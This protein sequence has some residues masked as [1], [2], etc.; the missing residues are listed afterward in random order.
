MVESN[1]VVVPAG[2]GGPPAGQLRQLLRHAYEDVPYY[3][4]QFDRLRLRPEDFRS[5]DDLQLLPLLTK[6]VVR[7]NPDRFLSRKADAARPNQVRAEGPCRSTATRPRR[8]YMKR[9]SACASGWLPAINQGTGW[10]LS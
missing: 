6:D 2:V 8:T 10:P 7:R 4:D 5:L 3:H 9:P 1:R